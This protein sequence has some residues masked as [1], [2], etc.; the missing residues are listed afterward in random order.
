MSDP[1]KEGVR[2]TI[3]RLRLAGIK[4]VMLTGDQP[5]TALAIAR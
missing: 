2:D 1:V 5:E 4:V 3:N